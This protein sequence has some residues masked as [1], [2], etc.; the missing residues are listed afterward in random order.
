MNI[1]YEIYYVVVSTRGWGGRPE[2][3]A[4]ETGARDPRS[5]PG[6]GPEAI[7]IAI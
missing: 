4:Q 5:P 2:R 7:I 6:R 3:P 1:T